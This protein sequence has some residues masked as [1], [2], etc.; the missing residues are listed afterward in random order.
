MWLLGQK[1]QVFTSFV[2]RLGKTMLL[3]M[4]IFGALGLSTSWASPKINI[5]IIEASQQANAF[6]S[7]G[8]NEMKS[9]LKASFKQFNH[10]K[11]INQ[12][13]LNL[14]RNMVETIKVSSD[15]KFKLGF[16]A[17]IKN[18]LR[19]E[20]DFPQKASKH[21]VNAKFNK[22]FFEGFK[23]QGKTYLI[24]FRPHE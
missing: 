5:S 13:S 16:K 19:V 14:K 22:L 6:N 2:S 3:S 21:T 8:L 4:L 12:L 15:F 17:L 9:T 11:L 20:I 23:W 24:S 7:S 18:G 10:F 1:K